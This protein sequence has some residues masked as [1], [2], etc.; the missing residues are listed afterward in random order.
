MMKYMPAVL[1]LVV[2][3]VGNG[4]AEQPPVH[5]KDIAAI[6]KEANGAV[7][8]II[9]SD[10]E[11]HPIVQGSGFF[12]STNGW[13]VTNYHVIKSGS[14]AVIKLPDGAFFVVD[15][16]LVSD[17]DRDVAVIKVHG[18]NFRPLPLGNSDR[19]QVGD[20]VVAIGNPLSLEA[21]V[22]NGIVS[23]IRTVE[24]KAG[25]VL[26]ITAPISPGS[27]G[28]PLFNMAGEVVGI[29]TAHLNGGENLNFAVPINYVHAIRGMSQFSPAHALPDEAEEVV[30]EPAATGGADL[31]KTLEWMHNTISSGDWACTPALGGCTLPLSL[32]SS[33]CN[34]RKITT[35]A[36]TK[37]GRATFIEDRFNLKDIDPKSITSE[38]NEM[39]S[40][41][42]PGHF[43]ADLRRPEDRDRCTRENPAPPNS[44]TVK[45]RTTNDINAITRRIGSDGVDNVN[46]M[47]NVV[48]FD[49]TEEYAPRFKKALQHAVILCGGKPST[50]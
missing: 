44:V 24:E 16:V 13:V 14:S 48:E 27:S 31:T 20:E 43:C 41:D 15:G 32:T 34:I 2:A 38:V 19:L 39:A 7:V 10:K 45:F 36:A 6:A 29:T 49:L 22:S 26:Q 4:K 50:F 25:K 12:I 42:S 18:N 9:M 28:G 5:Q 40:S 17:K 47:V 35:F 30:A 11:G 33:S 3:L 21:T 46:V 8:S 37:N 23:G 1:L